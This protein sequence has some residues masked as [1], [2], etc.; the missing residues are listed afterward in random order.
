[1]TEMPDVA[2]LG[3][4]TPRMQRTPVRS[5]V[6]VRWLT[7]EANLSEQQGQ[8]AACESGHVFVPGDGAGMLVAD[9]TWQSYWQLLT[10][11]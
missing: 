9:G 2:P 10:Q 5:A 11:T 7:A 1:M 8:G 6:S 3:P 4:C